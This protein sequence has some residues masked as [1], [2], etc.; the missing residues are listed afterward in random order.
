MGRGVGREVLFPLKR[1]KAYSKRMITDEREDR[2]KLHTRGGVALCVAYSDCTGGVVEF[3]ERW[4]GCK[5][6]CRFCRHGHGCNEGC[7]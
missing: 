7:E 1:G 4:V 2:N 3:I 6:F 5:G